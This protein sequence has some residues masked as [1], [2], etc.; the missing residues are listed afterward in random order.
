M[1][2]PARSD[3]SITDTDP[4]GF[5]CDFELGDR[6]VALSKEFLAMRLERYDRG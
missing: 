6:T 1:P 5:D 2:S 3:R 4:S